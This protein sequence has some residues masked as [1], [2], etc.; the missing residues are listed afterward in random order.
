[1]HVPGNGW[2]DCITDISLLRTDAAPA[3]VPEPGTLLLLGLGLAGVATMGRKL[4]K[5]RRA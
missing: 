2:E 3:P 5:G 4:G 1:M